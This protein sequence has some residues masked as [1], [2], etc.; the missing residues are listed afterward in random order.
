MSF[1]FPGFVILTRGSNKKLGKKTIFP[2]K[3]YLCSENKFRIGMQPV[4]ADIKRMTDEGN[5]AAALRLV[6]S[7]LAK[8]G[9]DAYLYYLKGK[10]HMKTSDWREAAN[11]FLRSKALDAAGPATEALML[12]ENIMDFYNKEMYNH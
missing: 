3:T 2:R 10:I 5:V 7:S 6:D 9:D 8:R 4:Y 11:C 12:L 1:P